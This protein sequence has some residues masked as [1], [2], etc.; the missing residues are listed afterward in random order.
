MGKLKYEYV[1][2]YQEKGDEDWIFL[3]S[4]NTL[5]KAKEEVEYQKKIDK[6]DYRIIGKKTFT[7]E[8][9]EVIE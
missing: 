1:V 3:N 7:I 6:F 4:F 8:W 5:E 9:I 2:E